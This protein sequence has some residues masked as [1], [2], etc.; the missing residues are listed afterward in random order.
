MAIEVV[1]RAASQIHDLV[2]HHGWDIAHYTQQ[3]WPRID[4]S[5]TGPQKLLPASIFTGIAS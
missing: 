2:A 4:S 1:V 3:V 5:K